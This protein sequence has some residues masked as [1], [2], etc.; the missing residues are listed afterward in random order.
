MTCR[1]PVLPLVAIVMLWFSLFL[2][3]TRLMQ[4]AFERASAAADADVADGAVR[5]TSDADSA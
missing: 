2:K 5:C 3:R 1:V 4:Q